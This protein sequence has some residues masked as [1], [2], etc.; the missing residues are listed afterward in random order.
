MRSRKEVLLVRKLQ[1]NEQ[2]D[3]LYN[4]F[5]GISVVKCCMH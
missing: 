1:E 4:F 5:Y 2:M 3:L